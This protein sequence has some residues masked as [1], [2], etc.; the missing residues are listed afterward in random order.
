MIFDVVFVGENKKLIMFSLKMEGT[1]PTLSWSFEYH[2]NLVIRSF[3]NNSLI[4]YES[5][6]KHYL[7]GIDGTVATT[8]DRVCS[9]PCVSE[10]CVSAKSNDYVSANWSVSLGSI[11]KLLK[12]L[13]FWAFHMYHR[14]HTNWWSSNSGITLQNKWSIFSKS[15]LV[16]KI[17]GFDGI[18]EN[19]Q[20]WI[21]S[22]HSKKHMIYWFLRCSTTGTNY[23]PLQSSCSQIFL[24]CYISRYQLLYEMF[25]LRWTS[26][27]PTKSF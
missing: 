13:A 14:I 15:E 24:Y 27:F 11:S 16:G 7:H 5:S 20:T 4:F 17:F 18:L 12:T 10:F 8:C 21:T 3:E 23:I 19:A 25:H 2:Q 26:Y 9:I 1:V 6:V 22:G